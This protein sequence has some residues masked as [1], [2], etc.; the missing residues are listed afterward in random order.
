MSTW[1]AVKKRSR[2]W[3]GE[4]FRPHPVAEFEWLWMRLLFAPIVLWEIWD[5]HPY[6]HDTQTHP[7]GVAHLFDLTW[8]S[9]EWVRPTFIALAIPAILLYLGGIRLALALG[10]LCLIN[11]LPRTLANSQGHINHS[12]Q[13]VSVALLTQFVVA[14]W[15]RWR[16]RKGKT[17]QTE[18]STGISFAS[19]Q[20]YYTQGIITGTY[21]VA[22]LSK[23]LNSKGMWFWNAPYISFDLVKSQRQQ[24]Y[25][26]LEDLSMLT[27]APAAQ[28]VME[29]P[30][31]ARIG[32][33]GAFFL[34]LF[35]IVAMKN[36]TW[37]FWTGIAL[38]ALHRGILEVMN[39]HF[40]NNE[41]LLLIFFLNF[42][43]WFWWLGQK[44]RGRTTE[45]Y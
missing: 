27:T 2:T 13:I 39:L 44:I 32:F 22:G 12:H 30:M 37:A 31:L 1:D 42:P 35:A 24:Y 40:Y 18:D 4:G 16:Q 19:W 45:L 11:I 23:L 29:N 17:G 15:W 9:Q 33:A 5:F 3:L 25:K 43:F 21:V 14:V 41:L 8:I 26:E 20:I 6:V 38:I 10:V 28:W 36:R 7:S 34:E